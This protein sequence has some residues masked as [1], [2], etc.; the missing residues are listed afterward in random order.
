[1]RSEVPGEGIGAPRGPEAEPSDHALGALTFVNPFA[2]D[3][4]G[5]PRQG[6]A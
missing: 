2:A 3:A 1:V 4:L 6:V 5:T